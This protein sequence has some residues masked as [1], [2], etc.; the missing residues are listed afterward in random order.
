M[1]SDLET[2]GKEFM[3]RVM[4]SW[5]P[6]ADAMLDMI[7]THLP[8]PVQAQ[9]YRTEILYEGPQDDEAAVGKLLT[10]RKIANWMPTKIAKNLTYFF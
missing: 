3:R 9:A 6:A 1:T 10:L 7:V 5:L 2:E 8:S 4:R